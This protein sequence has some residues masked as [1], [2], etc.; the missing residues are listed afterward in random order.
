MCQ[1]SCY[2]K[3]LSYIKVIFQWYDNGIQLI[4]DKPYY[5]D[6]HSSSSQNSPSVNFPFIYRSNLAAVAHGV[7]TYLSDVQSLW[8]LSWCHWWRLTVTASLLK[9][10]GHP[11]LGLS[12]WSICVKNNHGY[13]PFGIFSVRF[14]T[15]SWLIIGFVTIVR[16]RLPPEFTSGIQWGSC[17]SSICFLF[18]VLQLVACPLVLF[19]HLWCLSFDLRRMVTLLVFSNFQHNISFHRGSSKRSTVFEA[20]MMTITPLK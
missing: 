12:L 17:Y 15:H 10:Y 4:K 8:F 19:W 2:I 1:F 16:Q 18:N 5:L 20:I 9:F 7:C 11:R 14:Y 13:V 3:T 6:L